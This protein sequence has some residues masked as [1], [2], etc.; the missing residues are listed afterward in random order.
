VRVHRGLG[1]IDGTDR[2]GSL[3][4]R[5]CLSD[6]QGGQHAIDEVAVLA[7]GQMACRDLKVPIRQAGCSRTV[8]IWES[9]DTANLIWDPASL[10]AL[11]SGPGV[12]KDA[13]ASYRWILVRDDG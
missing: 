10:D 8:A 9:V 1:W 4:M 13:T 12:Q 2:H 6:P 11:C 3:L 7:V 5:P